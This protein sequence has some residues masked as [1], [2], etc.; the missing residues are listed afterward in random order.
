MTDWDNLEG[1]AL[2]L[3]LAQLTAGEGWTAKSAPPYHAS[4]DASIRDLVGLLGPKLEEFGWVRELT[5]DS[6]CFLSWSS[7]TPTT[8]ART[9]DLLATAFAR[10]IGKALEA[11][12]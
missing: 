6:V 11:L 12:S 2:D 10:A 3:A 4:V 7:M 5:G 8:Y 1:E 9:R